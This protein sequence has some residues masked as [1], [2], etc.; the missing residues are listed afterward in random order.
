MQQEAAP[1]MD[2][3]DQVIMAAALVEKAEASQQVQGPGE[4]QVSVHDETGAVVKE[5]LVVIATPGNISYRIAPKPNN[6]PAKR[7]KLMY[8]DKASRRF[9]CNICD[10]KFKE[11][12]FFILSNC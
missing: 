5:D 12:F 9:M 2:S 8:D 3:L 10:N 1:E 6:Q 7:Q 4:I 11:V